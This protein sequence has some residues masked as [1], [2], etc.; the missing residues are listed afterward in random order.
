MR[1]ISSFEIV[2]IPDPQSAF[3]SVFLRWQNAARTVLKNVFSLFGD[4]GGSFRIASFTTAESTF[5]GGI[6]ELAGTVVTI[7]AVQWYATSTESEE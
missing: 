7:S 5:G 4:M 1:L 3:T 2:K 6:N